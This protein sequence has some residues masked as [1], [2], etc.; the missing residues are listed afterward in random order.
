VSSP[1][2]VDGVASA[3]PRSLAREAQSRQGWWTGIPARIENVLGQLSHA[4]GRGWAGTRHA[5][6]RSI[7]LRVVTTTVV[8][9]M[10]VIAALGFLLL[11]AVRGGLLHAK[12]A[13]AL[14]EAYAGLSA[15]QLTVNNSDAKDAAGI[16][17]L[18]QDLSQDLAQRS[19][20]GRLYAVVVLSSASSRNQEIP[21]EER[22]SSFVRRESVP[23]DLRAAVTAEPGQHYQ[24]TTI[25]YEDGAS[26]PQ[27]GLAVGALLDV[28]V[29]GTYEL[30]YLFPLSQEQ[31]TLNLVGRTLALGG[32]FLVLLIGAIAW[33]VTR[34]VV[35]PV[36]AAART[37]ERLSAGRLQERMTVRGED[38]LARLASSFNTMAT[39]LQRQIRQLEDLSRV[40]R[41]F[42]SDVSHELRT[43]L[44]TVRMAAD[45]LHEA[46]AQFDPST[47]RAAEL[48]QAQLDRFEALLTDLLEISRYDAGAAVLDAES[49]D[50]RNVARRVAEVALPLAERKGSVLR[51]DFPASPCEAEVDSRRI[52]R[53][54]R[55]LVVNAIEHGEG[56]DILLRI[57]ADDHAV[58]VAVRDHGVG[59][60]PG[61]AALVFNRFWR[62]DP[63]RARTTGGS[64]LGLAIALEDA[65]LHGGWLQAWGDPGDGSQ[66]RLT[67]PRRA[68]GDLTESPI[69]LEPADSRRRSA[70]VLAGLRAAP[71]TETDRGGMR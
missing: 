29:A 68:G 17:V 33:L 27:P 13:S 30:Y 16:D 41:R 59:L 35:D 45:V 44:T 4:G 69:P 6:R 58:A 14:S 15:A 38:D 42:V 63:A 71:G 55:N 12:E 10:S 11:N 5:W 7:Q 2:G 39:N 64:G 51:L 37:A 34:Q 70:G 66:F 23:R 56:R 65:R 36:R 20:R 18:M 31:Q 57:R 47:A 53:V 24:Y 52:E 25:Y 26:P 3:R 61:E 40:Q 9:S 8:L 62:A 54:L 48:L 49:I 46:R 50:L 21:P 43:P 1:T 60:R 22:A 28:K 19:S 32:V 67:L